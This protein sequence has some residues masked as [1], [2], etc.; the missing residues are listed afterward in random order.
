MQSCPQPSM[1]ERVKILHAGNLFSTTTWSKHLQVEGTPPSFIIIV[2]AITMASQPR[3]E[4]SNISRERRDPCKPRRTV[5]NDHRMTTS[6]VWTSSV[7][8]NQPSTTLALP[9][10]SAIPTQKART[11][12]IM[13][14]VGGATRSVAAQFT[15]GIRESLA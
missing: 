4:D 8:R 11:Q 3:D 1:D 15:A 12:A 2:I 13:Q 7:R 6:E 14:V 5:G 10:H 9:R